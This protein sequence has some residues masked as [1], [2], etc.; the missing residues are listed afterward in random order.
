MIDHGPAYTDFRIWQVPMD[1]SLRHFRV[2][3]EYQCPKTPGNLKM[4]VLHLTF[5]FK[6]VELIGHEYPTVIR[7]LL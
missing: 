6:T 5:A 7:T 4:L 3:V 1:S 2:L